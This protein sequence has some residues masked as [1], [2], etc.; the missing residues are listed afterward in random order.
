MSLAQRVELDTALAHPGERRFRLIA[1][2]VG[3]ALA[4]F[5][6]GT[7]AGVPTDVLTTIFNIPV[8][9]VP[10]VAW[11]AWW[12]A[13]GFQRRLWLLLSLSAT[14]WLL[15]SLV[16]LA[17]WYDAGQVI[18]EPPG[19]W[20]LVFLASYLFALAAIVTGM[21]SSVILKHAL[22]DT[23]VIVAAGIAVGAAFIG[24]GLRDGVT[25]QALAT[26]V[27][28]S[29]GI[30]ML[31]LLLSAGLGAW[32]GLYR[33]TALV[34]IGE[35]AVVIG[36][37][38]YSYAAV[39]GEYGDDR[40]ANMF[41]AIGAGVSA[42]GGTVIILRIDRPIRQTLP[43]LARESA[44]ARL[45]L[46]AA[47]GAI[48]ASL[49]VIAVGV[50]SDLPI[51]TYTGVAACGAILLAMALRASVAVGAAERL[52]A[53]CN[54]TTLAAE[55]EHDRL[56]VRLEAIEEERDALANEVMTTR[57]VSG[58]FADLL[59]LADDATA[60]KLREAMDEATWEL[61]TSA[62]SADEGG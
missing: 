13:P 1:W 18:P 15:G 42:L 54:A 16:W 35:V 27:R 61:L 23:M 10:V 33:S 58:A 9:F 3:G 51:V 56:L 39:Q 22:L 7:I 60:G 36:S 53:S 6:I 30:V 34:G 11:W 26:V 44:G 2:I 38:I 17:F 29:L 52:A 50:Q 4:A 45:M 5:A 25:L 24:A 48:L 43:P 28:P 31:M 57:V 40:W 19:P 37:L 47:G 49:A 46:V 8:A 62:E 12:R 21:R 41:W 59:A 14:M 32:N 20:D 55:R